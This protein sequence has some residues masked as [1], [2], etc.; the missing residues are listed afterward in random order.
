MARRKLNRAQ[1]AR[2]EHARIEAEAY[3]YSVGFW[4]RHNDPEQAA[5]RARL[6]ARWAYIVIDGEQR[7]PANNA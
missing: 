5:R 3:G 2:I 1:V 6:A 4:I 7:F